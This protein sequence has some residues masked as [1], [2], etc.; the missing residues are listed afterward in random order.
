M[1]A[2]MTTVTVAA[3]CRRMAPTARAK[4]AKTATSAAVP[5]MTRTSVSVLA[6]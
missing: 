5:A 3:P 1:T 2:V 6:G 4:T